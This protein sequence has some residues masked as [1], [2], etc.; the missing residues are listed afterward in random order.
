MPP[1]IISLVNFKGGV[2]KTSLSVNLAACLAHTHNQR[3]LLVDCD[4]QSNSSIWLLGFTQW[5]FINQKRG[6]TIR[7]SYLT[8]S[9]PLRN[10]I[11]RRVLSD[12]VPEGPAHNLDLLPA[13]YE[14]FDFE[15]SELEDN[16]YLRFDEELN[17]VRDDYDYIIFDCPP[18]LFKASQT[19]TFASDEIYVPCN[20]DHLSTIGL[21]LL[22]SKLTSFYRKVEVEALPLAND[23]QHARIS[24]VILNNVRPTQNVSQ[25]DTMMKMT[26]LGGSEAVMKGATVMAQRIHTA[27]F[28]GGVINQNLPVVLAKGVGV[29]GAAAR[30][31]DDY[32]KLATRIHE[33]RYR[34]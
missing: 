23:Y 24:G 33:T 9:P 8:D 31:R 25:I 5:N 4:L 12:R 7:G 17:S 27:A 28:A 29:D 26:L 34:R 3:V 22:I 21:N 18:N 30:L 14:L 10:R 19:A 16:F 32:I 6:H 11:V 15:E 1:R 20:P 13:T 2:G